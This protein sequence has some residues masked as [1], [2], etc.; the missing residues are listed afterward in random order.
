M[1]KTTITQLKYERPM[2]WFLELQSNFGVI[3]TS[4]EPGA[5]GGDDPYNP[6]GDY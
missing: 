2:L 6:G 1:N 3:M 4:P 5:P